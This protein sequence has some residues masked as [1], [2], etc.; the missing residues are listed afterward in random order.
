MCVVTNRRLFFVL[1][2]V[3]VVLPLIS[4]GADMKTRDQWQQRDRVVGDLGL[5]AGD[6]VADIGCGRGYFTFHLAKAVGEEGTVYATEITE[7]ALK[8]VK[9]KVAKDKTQHIKPVLSDPTSTK[10]PDNCLNA[11]IIVNVLHHVPKDQRPALT[12]DIVRSIKPGGHLY[13]LDWRVESPI[14]HDVNR[15]IPLE[16]LLKYGTDN[17]LKLDAE[18][19]YLEHQVFLRFQK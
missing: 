5:N 18:F 6:V 8:S 1:I 4:F 16:E 13:I 9:E 12:K 14:K 3:A 11:A 2:L 19:H 10:V 7:K 17:G 15:R